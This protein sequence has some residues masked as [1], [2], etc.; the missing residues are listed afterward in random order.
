MEMRQKV[1]EV[2]TLICPHY[3]LRRNFPGGVVFKVA[4]VK[5]IPQYPLFLVT[6]NEV[7]SG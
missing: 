7:L 5:E 2:N 6:R 1:R 3:A 4:A